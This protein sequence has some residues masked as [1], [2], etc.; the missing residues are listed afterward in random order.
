[1]N[2]R[3]KAILLKD[4]IQILYEKEGRSFSY[5][6]RLLKIDR[7]TIT[8]LIREWGFEKANLKHLT[9]SNQKILNK[10]K[11]QII[12]LLRKKMNQLLNYVKI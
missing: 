11:N 8:T 10:K 1:M 3:D 2:N 4:T 9:P 7:K 6:E 12:S 5:I